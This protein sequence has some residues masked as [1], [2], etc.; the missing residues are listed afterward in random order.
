MSQCP[1]CGST[2]TRRIPRTPMMRLLPFAQHI[3]CSHCGERSL[4]LF[5]QLVRAR[6]ERQIVRKPQARR[7][8]Y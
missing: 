4:I 6:A 8:V 5:P 2:F 7:Q 3:L 1:D